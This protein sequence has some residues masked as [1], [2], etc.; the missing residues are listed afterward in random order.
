M[1]KIKFE[2][3]SLKIK[4][5]IKLPYKWPLFITAASVLIEISLSGSYAQFRIV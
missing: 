4:I 2:K 5:T 3:N 1:H